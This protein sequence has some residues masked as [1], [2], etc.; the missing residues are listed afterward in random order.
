MVVLYNMS[1]NQTPEICM[2]A[3]K[4]NGRA[5]QYVRE[6]NKDICMEA[7]KQSGR[8]LQ[9]VN[10]QTPEICMEAVEQNGLALQYVREQNKDICMEAIKQ[11]GHAL[12]FVKIYDKDVY[13]LAYKIKNVEI[14]KYINFDIISI[15]DLVE[16][17]ETK[18]IEVKIN[19]IDKIIYRDEK[20]GNV[21]CINK[22]NN[23]FESILDH[24]QKTHGETE[25]NKI[26]ICNDT[27]NKSITYEEN[28]KMILDDNKLHGLYVI[29][30]NK[31]VYELYDKKIE[32]INN[33]W[34]MNNM[35]PKII[36]EKIG[37]YHELQLDN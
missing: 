1:N 11:N 7:M 20:T 6:Q 30:K 25:M 35:I 29:E 16:R 26:K 24:I 4:Q 15:K 33:G 8:A 5:L 12:Q 19:I 28:K 13:K 23:F 27:L 21:K 37:E 31:N 22:I 10:N 36:M 17:I 9:Y 18:Y 32:M 34:L 14:L 3:V 2:E